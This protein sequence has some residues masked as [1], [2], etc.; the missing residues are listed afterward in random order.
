MDFKKAVRKL[1]ASTPS[2][3]LG[4]DLGSDFVKIAQVEL[5]GSRPRSGIRDY[6]AAANLKGA[7]L[8]TAKDEMAAFL[9]DLFN[10]TTLPPNSRFQHQR[11][12]RLR[13]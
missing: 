13:A 3:V 9:H 12:Q 5:K 11:P 8:T 4:I 10:S 7:A 6:G 1:F 2:S